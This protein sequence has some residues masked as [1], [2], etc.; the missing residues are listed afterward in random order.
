MIQRGGDSLQAAF[1]AAIVNNSVSPRI[2]LRPCLCYV[3][4]L[5]FVLRVATHN[6]WLFLLAG[7]PECMA[8]YDG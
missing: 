2:Q 7:D 6:P 3:V 4:V 5:S 8:E 1:C